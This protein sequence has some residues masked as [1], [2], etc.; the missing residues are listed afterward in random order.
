M[1]LLSLRHTGA[2]VG[3]R[4][5]PSCCGFA[6]A[7]AEIGRPALTV[8]TPRQPF[9]SDVQDGQLNARYD[10]KPK[11]RSV[12]KRKGNYAHPRR[13]IYSFD[14]ALLGPTFVI[15]LYSNDVKNSA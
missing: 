15:S 12:T 6:T 7:G 14:A 5:E 10:K 13:S 9:F 2:F 1:W 11:T 3:A 8:A 4:Q